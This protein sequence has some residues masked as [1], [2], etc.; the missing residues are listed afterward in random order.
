MPKFEVLTKSF[1]NNSLAKEGDI[2]DYDGVPGTNLKPVDGG[3]KAESEAAALARKA[4]GESLARFHAAAQAGD[5]NA[6]A[7]SSGAVSK[8]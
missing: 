8:D 1:I 4:D 7:T 5:A 3:K 2:V 6:A